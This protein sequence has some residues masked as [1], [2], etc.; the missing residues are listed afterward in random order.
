MKP[1]FDMQWICTALKRGRIEDFQVRWLT[2]KLFEFEWER[3]TERKRFFMAQH[4]GIIWAQFASVVKERRRNNKKNSYEE[5]P[6]CEYPETALDLDGGGIK[7]EDGVAP[8]E[9]L[10]LP[11]AG[12][13]EP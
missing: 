6:A 1:L 9:V 10:R 8:R 13:V 12:P 3:S 11:Y 4:H 7:V 2:I 5:F